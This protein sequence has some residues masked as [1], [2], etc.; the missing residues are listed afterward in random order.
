M[1]LVVNRG[2]P[3]GSN[4]GMPRGR[5]FFPKPM[6]TICESFSIRRVSRPSYFTTS[7]VG[8][9]ATFST[10]SQFTGFD[11]RADYEKACLE[12]FED[13][14]EEG[15]SRHDQQKVCRAELERGCDVVPTR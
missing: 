10:W 3:R 8:A 7:A 6:T 4:C 12:V 11:S 5:R 14:R 15:A 9:T 2:T 1:G 13:G